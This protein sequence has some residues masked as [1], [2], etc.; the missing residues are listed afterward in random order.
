LGWITKFADHKNFINKE[1]LL[2][3]KQQ[4]VTRKVIGFEMIER[5]IPRQDYTIV[6]ANGNSIGT[7][8]SGTQGP[9][10]QK[11]IGTALI[12]AEHARLGNE[13]FVKIRE[14]IVK[15]VVVKMPFYKS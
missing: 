7:V 2:K 13:I 5:G 15:A 4:G 14:K 1:N 11:A 10:V 12:K 9:S 8:C 6:D 3:Q